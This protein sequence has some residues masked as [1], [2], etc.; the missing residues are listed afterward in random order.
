MGSTNDY[1]TSESDEHPSTTYEADIKGFIGSVG[2]LNVEKLFNENKVQL[3]VNNKTV[4]EIPHKDVTLGLIGLLLL[5]MGDLSK[6]GNVITFNSLDKINYYKIMKLSGYHTSKAV[7]YT[8]I[9]RPYIRQDVQEEDDPGSIDAPGTGSATKYGKGVFV[10]QKPCELIDQLF[11]L[12]GSLRA[13]NTSIKLK[14]EIRS[15]NDELFS[16]KAIAPNIHELL[17][18]KIRF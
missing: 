14:Q 3:K 1:L 2:K 17:Y 8:A 15:I 16:I 7:K 12:N 9:I 10:Y 6:L 11:L 13:G 18:K 4:L 5:P